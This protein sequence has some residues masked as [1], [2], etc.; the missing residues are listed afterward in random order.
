MGTSVL[1]AREK[2]KEIETMQ[3]AFS[4]IG[5]AQGALCGSAYETPI[6][7]EY[8]EDLGTTAEDNSLRIERLEKSFGGSDRRLHNIITK[9]RAVGDVGDGDYKRVDRAVFALEHFIYSK[10][11]HNPHDEFLAGMIKLEM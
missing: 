2:R 5:T 11:C 3:C 4:S 10:H 7:N 9:L 6:R 1:C 8:F